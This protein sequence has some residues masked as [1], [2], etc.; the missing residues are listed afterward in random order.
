MDIVSDC[1]LC[2]KDAIYEGVCLIALNKLILTNHNV[3][4]D[5]ALTYFAKL[6]GEK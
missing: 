1:L 4:G 2:V 6:I 5:Y 3:F